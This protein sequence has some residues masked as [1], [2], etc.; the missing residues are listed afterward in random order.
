MDAKPKPKQKPE[1]ES[2]PNLAVVK[3]TSLFGD[4]HEA[5][6]QRIG[7]TQGFVWQWAN[8]K[9][10]VPPEMCT[11]IECA[12]GGEVTCEE[13]RPETR[14]GRVP[15]PDW[16]WHPRGRP[17]VEVKHEVCAAGDM[18]APPEGAKS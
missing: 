15:D 1:V 12:T 3:A 10:P 18:P 8:G 5:L 14:W 2:K 9:R 4:S 11:A 7:S 16:P 6:A 13:L 17:V